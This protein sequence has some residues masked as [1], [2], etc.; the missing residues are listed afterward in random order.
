MDRVD[1]HSNRGEDEVCKAATT[2]TFTY[3]KYKGCSWDRISG[4]WEKGGLLIM[5]DLHNYHLNLKMIDKFFKWVGTVWTFPVE[6]GADYTI[7][8]NQ[9]NSALDHAR[10]QNRNEYL[11]FLEQWIKEHPVHVPTVF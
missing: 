10:K 3:R 1:L 2:G 8:T 7:K 11:Q 5:A 9:R 6:A 4:F